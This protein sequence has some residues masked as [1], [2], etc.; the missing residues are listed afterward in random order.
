MFDFG[1]PV[2]ELCI[3]VISLKKNI[4]RHRNGL[5]IGFFFK[6]PYRFFSFFRLIWIKLDLNQSGK[7]KVVG[8]I[9]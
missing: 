9:G 8:L 3:L 6:H 5:E 7:K 4:T 2:A 1:P